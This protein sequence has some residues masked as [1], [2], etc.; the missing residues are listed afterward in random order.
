MAWLTDW[1]EGQIGGREQLE[2]SR[3]K[4]RGPAVWMQRGEW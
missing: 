3:R 1:R 4:V 2:C